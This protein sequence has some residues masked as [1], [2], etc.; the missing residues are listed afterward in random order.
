[1][2]TSPTTIDLT[3]RNEL[4]LALPV[5]KQPHRNYAPQTDADPATDKEG[6]GGG[7]RT[8]DL[9]KE[10]AP[11]VQ[12]SDVEGCILTPLPLVDVAE[13]ALEEERREGN[14]GDADVWKRRRYVS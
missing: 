6:L 4:A 9:E 12:E 7:E 8:Q 11:G 2:K 5:Q 1:M 10:Q 14:D 3:D 13:D